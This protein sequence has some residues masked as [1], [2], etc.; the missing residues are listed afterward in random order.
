MAHNNELLSFNYGPLYGIVA[1]YFGLLGV[2]GGYL[3]D[4]ITKVIVGMALTGMPNG[5][6]FLALGFEE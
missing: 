4:R 1:H 3:W 2:P 6:V 5:L